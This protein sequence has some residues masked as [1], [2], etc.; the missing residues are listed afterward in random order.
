MEYFA[1]RFLFPPDA[2][3]TDESKWMTAGLLLWKGILR[4]SIALRQVRKQQHH[5]RD[6]IRK[7]PSS[8]CRLGLKTPSARSVDHALCCACNVCRKLMSILCVCVLSDS[9]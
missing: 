2:I 8:T 4:E 1:P 3:N 6:Q 7:P 5:S 9:S